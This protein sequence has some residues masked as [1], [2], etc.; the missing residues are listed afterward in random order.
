MYWPGESVG[1]RRRGSGRM[2]S[3]VRWIQALSLAAVLATYLLILLG[4]TVRV[5]NSGMG[6]PSWPLCAGQVGPILRFHPLMEQSH[7]YL[8]S[9]VTVLIV[10]LAALAWRSGPKARSVRAPAL[11]SVGVIAVQIVLG[12]VTV[13]TNNA[14]VTVAMHLV[15]ALMFLG[16]VTVTAVASLVAPE[17]PWCLRRQPGRL[18][19][20]A[21]AGLFLLL[22]SGSLVVDGGAQSAC[23]SWPACFGSRAPGAL[24]GLQLAHRSMVVVGGSLVVVYLVTLLRKEGVCRAQRVLALSGLLLL[25]VQAIVGAFDA[26]L[27]APAA[28]A[29]AHLA[30]ASALWAVLI[31]V[32]ALSARGTQIDGVFFGSDDEAAMAASGTGAPGVGG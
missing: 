20:I 15:V 19:W 5:S 14:P 22:I 4:S 23:E 25:V 21:I 11:M 32:A 1:V 28:L 26:T 3:G 8:A 29:D 27:G 9:I 16:I 12:A 30:L 31:A 2:D 24:V 18:A 17:R 13:I 7:R 6:C 10:V